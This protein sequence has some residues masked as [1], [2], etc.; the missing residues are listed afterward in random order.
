MRVPWSSRKN[1]ETEGDWAPPPPATVTA[2]VL[3]WEDSGGPVVKTPSFHC[4]GHDCNPWSRKV[5]F[6]MLQDKVK[7]SKKKDAATGRI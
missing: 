6:H 4:R 7:K 5:S 1:T 3:W 2:T